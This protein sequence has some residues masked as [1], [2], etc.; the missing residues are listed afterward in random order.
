[1]DH[2]DFE[3]FCPRFHHAIEL[4]GRRWT[5]AILRG[6]LAGRV[7]FND[8]AASVPG[9]SDRLLSERL[10]ELEAEGIVERHVYPETP[11]R[12]EYH[13]TGKGRALEAVLQDVA[14]WANDWVTPEQ[15]SRSQRGVA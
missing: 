10:K 2:S 15:A 7:R 8:L 6:L 13:L 5:G 14:G 11:V 4:I 1:M 12:I 3:T 9:L